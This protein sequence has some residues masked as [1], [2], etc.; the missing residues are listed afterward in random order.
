[1]S[2]TKGIADDAPEGLKAVFDADVLAFA[3]IATVIA[4]GD[5]IDPALAGRSV[6]DCGKLQA[7]H[8][9]GNL[10]L[11]PESVALECNTLENLAAEDFVADFHIRQGSSP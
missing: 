1:M 9:G 10:G 4:T 7:G 2:I 3:V 11:E 5:L 6:V 8:L